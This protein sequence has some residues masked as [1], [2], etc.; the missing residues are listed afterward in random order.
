MNRPTLNVI[1]RANDRPRRVSASDVLGQC[2]ST[3]AQLPA[4]Q[5]RLQSAADLGPRRRTKSRPT[6]AD[7]RRRWRHTVRRHVVRRV[8]CGREVRLRLVQ[9]HVSAPARERRRSVCARLA[10]RSDADRKRKYLAAGVHRRRDTTSP[11]DRFIYGRCNNVGWQ[12]GRYDY[13]VVT[14]STLIIIMI[15]TT[16]II[17]IIIIII[18][19]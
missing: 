13:T 15:T 2:A 11:E 9:L 18:T 5:V 7:R 12:W 19:L 16:T 1:F 4:D 10:L 6:P 3:R 14:A 8:N 17:I